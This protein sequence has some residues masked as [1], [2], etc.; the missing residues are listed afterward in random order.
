M[1][2]M[3]GVFCKGV[4]KSIVS[5]PLSKPSSANDSCWVKAAYSG[6]TKCPNNVSSDC[7]H[8]V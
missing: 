6:I 7:W 4:G 1:W 2:C 5:E 3:Q 8:S